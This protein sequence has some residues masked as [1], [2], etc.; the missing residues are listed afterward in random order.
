MSEDPST[1]DYENDSKYIRLI[2]YIEYGVYRVQV[3][4]K[5]GEVLETISRVSRDTKG[6]D[7][8]YVN[9]DSGEFG[10]QIMKGFILSMPICKVIGA[11]HEACKPF[12]AKTSAS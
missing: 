9:F 8:E 2:E 12:A 6:S 1:F 10:T 4:S 11:F 3:K 5:S 7:M